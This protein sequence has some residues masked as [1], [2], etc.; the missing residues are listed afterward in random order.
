MLV[1]HDLGRSSLAKLNKGWRLGTSSRDL[2]AALFVTALYLERRRR[3]TNAFLLTNAFV[4]SFPFSS[5][6]AVLKEYCI[7]RWLSITRHLM[8]RDAIEKMLSSE[9]RDQ[10][11]NIV[12]VM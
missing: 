5:Q 10:V 11:I 2:H 8:N 3:L 4:L 1:G 7:L 6:S 9:V 12:M